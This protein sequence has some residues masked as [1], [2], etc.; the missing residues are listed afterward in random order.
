MDENIK[1]TFVVLAYKESEYLEECIKSVLDQKYKSKVVIGTSTPNDYISKM[2]EK[3]K[4]DIIVHKDS[5]GIGY[6]YDFATTCGKTDIVTIAHQDDIYDF[7][8]SHAIVEAYEKS[9]DPLIIFPNYYEIKKSGIDYKNINF[10]IKAIMLFPLRFRALR[11][12][13]FIKRLSLRFGDPICCPATAYVTAKLQYPLFACDDLKCSVDWYAYEKL[14]RVSGEFIYVPKRL[15]GHR[16]HE[17]S[18]TAGTIGENRRTIEDLYILR[19]FW[20]EPIVKIIAKVYRL[21]ER[22]YKI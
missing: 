12:S 19:R 20:P 22:A 5:K 13:K 17:S 7:D 9:K 10:K 16:L 6:D 4:L 18:T 21:S 1:H 14:S 2:A 11:G 3:Y 15:M 8:Y